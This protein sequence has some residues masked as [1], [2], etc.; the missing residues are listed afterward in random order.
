MVPACAPT[1]VI[2]SPIA[3]TRS[4]QSLEPAAEA[5][6]ASRLFCAE[7]VSEPPLQTANW[8]GAWTIDAIVPS[9]TAPNRELVRCLDD[10]RDSAVRHAPD[11]TGDRARA[12]LNKKS[13]R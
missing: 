11:R 3:L 10:R 2:A 12:G 4:A 1:Y 7:V 6:A 9:G 13:P 8:F 5:S